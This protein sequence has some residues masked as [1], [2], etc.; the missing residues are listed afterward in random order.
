MRFK[1]LQ[2]VAWCLG[3]RLTVVRVQ[4][5]LPTWTDA[6]VKDLVDSILGSMDDDERPVIH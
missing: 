1:V 3:L 4:P 6:E 2:C 5:S